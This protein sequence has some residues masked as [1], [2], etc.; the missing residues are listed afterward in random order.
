MQIISTFSKEELESKKDPLD[1]ACHAI[2]RLRFV[3]TTIKNNSCDL[4]TDPLEDYSGEDIFVMGEIIS[5]STD[6]LEKLIDMSQNKNRALIH[7]NRMLKARI[8]DM[9]K[10]VAS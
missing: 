10:E 7:E 5:D 1:L 9:K 3:G 6:E 8:V 2:N 4:N